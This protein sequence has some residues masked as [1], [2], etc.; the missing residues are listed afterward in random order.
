MTAERSARWWLAAPY[1]VESAVALLAA[2]SSLTPSLL[3]KTVAV[4]GV[5]TGLAAV[6]GYA[7]GTLVRWL[8]TPLRRRL[9][10]RVRAWV[11]WSLLGLA[12][13]S[14]VAAV[15]FG[16][17]WR[18]DLAV[19]LGMRAP[20]PVTALG[21]LLIAVA[22]LLAAILVARATRF[23]VRW[24]ARHLSRV[25]PAW[26]APVLAGTLVLGLTVVTTWWVVEDRLLTAVDDSF[27]V[28]NQQVAPDAPP[29]RDPLRS[30]GP[31]SLVDWAALGAAGR[32]FV[33]LPAPEEGRSPVRVYAGI[34]SAGDL[35]ARAELVV[36]ELARTGAYR[37]DVVCVVVPTG[38]GWVDAAAVMTLEAL[39]RGDTAVA[40][41]QY[42]Y[43]PSV[44]SML[45]DRQRVED[46]AVAL[47][48]AV[49]RQWLALPEAE[50]PRLV[51]YGESLGS[52]GVE[53]AMARVPGAGEVVDGVLLVG[54]PNSNPT[55]SRLVAGRDPGSPLLAPVVDG[56]AS[57]RFWP[58]PELPQYDRRDDP[59]P[60]PPSGPRTLYLQHPSDPVVWWSPELLW[61]E[62]EWADERE[63]MNAP[64]LLWK[65]VVTFWQ[66]SGDAVFA[67]DVPSGHGHRYG[68]E[69]ADAWAALLPR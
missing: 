25:L 46:A 57:V 7:S 34:D 10:L 31:G 40:S 28:V 5:V 56:G 66:V 43:L 62:P 15:W 14:L 19:S 67:T 54:P 68:L 69:L 55:W 52:R 16:H 3:P 27:R 8:L 65:P 18:R 53:A 36:A 17:Q 4:Q 35:D 59:W 24:L 33:A 58:G 22:V 32:E 60:E 12:V 64:P 20:P 30:G 2:A 39:W 63:L 44:L 50:R 37:R 26:L 6:V 41:M 51:L 13:L 23:V 45:T 11:G 42:S 47:V 48:G 49:V 21:A 29:P 61:S 1:R 9:S 38:T